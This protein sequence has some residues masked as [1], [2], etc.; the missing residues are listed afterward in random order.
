MFIIAEIGKTKSVAPVIET[1]PI[2]VK[3]NFK[4]VVDASYNHIISKREVINELV[5]ALRVYPNIIVNSP[6]LLSE[7]KDT[8]S[9]CDVVVYLNLPFEFK[10]T[11]QYTNMCGIPTKNLHK[12]VELLYDKGVPDEVWATKSVNMV[13]KTQIISIEKWLMTYTNASSILKDN[14]VRDMASKM[15]A[16]RC[17]YELIICES[18]ADYVEMFKVNT[19]SCMHRHP[20]S[21]YY[22]NGTYQTPIW[23]AGIEIGCHPA[24][25][26]HFTKTSKGCYL[27]NKTTLEVVGRAMLYSDADGQWNTYEDVKAPTAGAQSAMK[28]YLDDIGAKGGHGYWT[29]NE[30]FVVPGF[31]IDG[32]YRCPL[33]YGDYLS[34]NMAIR[35]DANTHEYH[36]TPSST[37]Q[38]ARY[39]FKGYVQP[40]NVALLEKKQLNVI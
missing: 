18:P 7:L 31:L 27:R 39:N 33:P 28:R 4:D 2:K 21:P 1:V 25:W 6:C 38:I 19:R 15:K 8:D 14:E 23:D 40:K 35:Y 37:E 3:P 34:S 24:S 16:D 32:V 29:V 36:F 30:P 10:G 11:F 22:N 9:G 26:Y 20:N 17:K 5:E 13:L 12:N